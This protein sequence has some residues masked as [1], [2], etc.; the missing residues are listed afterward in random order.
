MGG[1]FLNVMDNQNAAAQKAIIKTGASRLSR[2]P[3]RLTGS[4]GKL[5]LPELGVDA[6]GT[7]AASL[8]NHQMKPNSLRAA[9]IS[10]TVV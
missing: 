9:A 6:A 2:R 10:L 1:I 7:P 8:I 3:L 5:A 4:C